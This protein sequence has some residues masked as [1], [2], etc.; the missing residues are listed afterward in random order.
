MHLSL[1]IAFS[2]VVFAS[3]APEDSLK[4]QSLTDPIKDDDDKV[5][6]HSP[7]E[8]DD[9]WRT[10][11]INYGR[12]Y[13]DESEESSRRNIFARHLKA[14]AINN[15]LHSKGLKSFTMGVNEFADLDTS[16]FVKLM[17]GYMSR[18][19]SDDLSGSAFLSPEVS[20]TLEDE[21]DWRDKGYVT[22]VKNQ[23]KCGSCWAF[24]ATGSLE[25]Q[26]FRKTGKL[27]D[28][29]EQQLVDCSGSFGN[30]G[31]NGGWPSYAFSYVK[32]IGGLDT[33]DSYPYDGK[34]E[35]CRYD[36]AS[37]GATC[38][39][40]VTITKNSESKLQESVASVGP[41]SV[42]IDASHTSFQLYR[43][44]V[45]DEPDCSSSDLDHA[46][47]VVGYGTAKS[48]EDFW[49]VKNSWGERWGMDGY[50][51]MSRNKE[52]QCGIASAGSY[53]LV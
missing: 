2:L 8:L 5:K 19:T 48:G 33:E 13:S 29:S 12:S 53:P 24:S 6:F 22:E 45:Y 28:L 30:K 35:E 3:A 26:T 15:Y 31:C 18:N 47:L 27:V 44:G 50:I 23:G 17:T 21:V 7:E 20:F 51:Q 36:P 10:F 39:G 14:I 4:W 9:E 46:V 25:G 43:K 11:K 37:S 52:N 1:L 38:S 32:S 42:A 40:Y 41:I 34:Q 49:I 16:E